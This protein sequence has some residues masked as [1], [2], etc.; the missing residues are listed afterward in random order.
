MAANASFAEKDSAATTDFGYEGIFNYSKLL[1][2][3]N[4][5]QG[6]AIEAKRLLKDY[7]AS[8][9]GAKAR[10]LFALSSLK[11]GKY[12]I[13]IKG[14]EKFLSEHGEHKHASLAE[15]KIKEATAL[16]KEDFSG[17]KVPEGLKTVKVIAPDRLRAVQVSLFHGKT[18]D[19]IDSELKLLKN[20]GVDT[21][22]LRVFHNPG[23]RYHGI[24]KGRAESGVYFNTEHAPVIGDVLG[25]VA[26]L[27][28]ANGLKLFAWMTTKYAD[29][30][31]ENTASSS[32]VKYDLE[33]N[34][35][36]ECRGLDLFSENSLEHLKGLY[37]DLAR[38]EIDG[39][40]FQDDL[41]LRHTE[42]F[43][44]DAR[45]AFAGEFGYMPNP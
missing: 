20:A 19:E 12:S 44:L 9:Y 39:I 4:D 10:Y 15:E 43:S 25:S 11:A 40:L 17:P 5:F 18:I 31:L 28:K 16:L 33:K 22:I 14:F 24:I 30:G 34:G 27:T 2:N 35:Y 38:Y 23:D 21:V 32:C 42:G 13:A 8:P 26:K 41:V 7:P 37:K 3:Q 45:R 6:S 36:A 1:F 29:Y